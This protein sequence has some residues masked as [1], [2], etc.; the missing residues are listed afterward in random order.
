MKGFQL[1]DPIP[2]YFEHKGFCFEVLH[3]K[4]VELDFQALMKSKDFLHR[5]SNSPWPE[6]HFTVEDNLFDLEWHYAEFMEKIAF[7]Y[8]ILDQFKINCLGCIYIRPISSIS[9]LSPEEKAKLE[10]FQFYISYWV[11]TEI[12]NTQLEYEIFNGIRDWLR[13]DWKFQS[14]LFVSNS[15]IP[16]QNE[17]HRNNQMVLFLELEEKKRHQQLWIPTKG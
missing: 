10:P 12:R 3:P 5:W 7:T 2:E 13:R 17:I 6:D 4:H 16:E 11:I 15:Q 14:I 9:S 1:P 8:T